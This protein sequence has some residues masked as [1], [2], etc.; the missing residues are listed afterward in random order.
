MDLMARLF[1]VSRHKQPGVQQKNLK[2]GEEQRYKMHIEPLK[3]PYTF[4]T[5]D[6]QIIMRLNGPRVPGSPIVRPSHAANS[7]SIVASKLQDYM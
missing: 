6:L 5:P 7:P 1:C 2:S 3:F 4:D